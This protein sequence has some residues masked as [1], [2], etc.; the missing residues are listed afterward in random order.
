MGVIKVPSDERA[1]STLVNLVNLT[2]HPL[3]R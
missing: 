3:N 1:T 2:L